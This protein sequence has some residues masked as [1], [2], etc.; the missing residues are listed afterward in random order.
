MVTIT[1]KY[2]YRETDASKIYNI[3]PLLYNYVNVM[4]IR[5]FESRGSVLSV[6]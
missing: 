5:P 1:A 4:H 2:V 3:E 6:H